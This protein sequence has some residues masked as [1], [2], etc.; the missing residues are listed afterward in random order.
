MK[1]DVKTYRKIPFKRLTKSLQ[2]L[3]KIIKNRQKSQKISHEAPK[4]RDIFIFLPPRAIF[5]APKAIFELHKRFL[6]RQKRFI[7]RQE[8]F[9]EP[10]GRFWG[11][12]RC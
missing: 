6:K 12:L 5:R 10:Q 8:R 7:E 1:N 11:P 9:L 4:N 3:P 2:I